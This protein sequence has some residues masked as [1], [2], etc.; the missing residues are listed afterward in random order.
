MSRQAHV[1]KGLLEPAGPGHQGQ[2]RRGEEGDGGGGGRHGRRPAP[3][4]LPQEEGHPDP[5]GPLCGRGH[6]AARQESHHTNHHCGGDSLSVA[7]GILYFPKQC[8]YF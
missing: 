3:A 1:T 6:P 8:L 5:P 4:L 2:A 7:S